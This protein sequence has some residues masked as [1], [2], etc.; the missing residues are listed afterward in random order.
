MSKKKIIICLVII[1]CIS[2]F[3]IYNGRKPSLEK[4]KEQLWLT[5]TIRL[6]KIPLE[7]DK[8][9]SCS[10]IQEEKTIQEIVKILND[11]YVAPKNQWYTLARTINYHLEFLDKENHVLTTLET[12]SS[13]PIALKRQ[14]YKYLIRLENET[15]FKEI[16]EKHCEKVSN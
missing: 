11:S 1:V 13:E 15:R 4:V 5:K 9:I 12:Q 16:L 6:E 8:P 2:A 3:V 10:E 14:G 7:S